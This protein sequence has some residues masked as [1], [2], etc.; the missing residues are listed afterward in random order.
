VRTATPDDVEAIAAIYDDQVRHSVATFDLE[1]PDPQTWQE[2]VA[3][4]GTGHHVLVC[5]IDDAVRGF[6][7][8]TTYRPRLGYDRTRE[9]SVYL[10]GDARGRGVG[11]ALYDEL[12][13]RLRTDGVHTVLAVVAQP[14]EASEALHRACGFERTGV[15]PEVGRKQGRWVDVAFW[16]LVLDGD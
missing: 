2:K 3:A 15:L 10:A 8:A 4:R 16:A 13:G 14:N 1:P 11:R 6:A 12:L 7:Y 5:E 9:V